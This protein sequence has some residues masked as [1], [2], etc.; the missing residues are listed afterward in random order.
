MKFLI[1]G[2]LYTSDL[3][4]E[5]TKSNLYKFNYYN[6]FTK[7]ISKK[8]HLYDD[9]GW[10]CTIKSFQMMLSVML[11]KI[12]YRSKTHII[13]NLYKE[14]GKLSI[15]NFVNYLNKKNIK[16]GNYLGSYLIASIY[17]EIIKNN[18]SLFNFTIH[19]TL[20]NII[21]IKKI[22]I[23]TGNLLLFSTKLGIEKLNNQYKELIYNC[24]HSSNFIGFIGGVGKSSYYFYGYDT[25]NNYLLYLDPHYITE[26]S[27]EVKYNKTLS[28]KDYQ[29]VYIDNLNPSITFC[30]YYENYNQFIELKKFLETKT[31]FNVLNKIDEKYISK[32]VKTKC[33]DWE[34]I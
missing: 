10:S 1:Q 4:L 13:T 25:I 18:K 26:Y 32:E 19:K 33:D 6:N 28:A 9:I 15:H 12:N 20:D 23:N 17:E 30:F 31:I 24:F 29:I 21:D 7:S 11:S 27:N 22:N 16:E 8:N 34:I 3:A 14:N 5:Y 2:T